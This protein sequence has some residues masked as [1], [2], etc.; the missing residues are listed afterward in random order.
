MAAVNLPHRTVSL[1]N[2]GVKVWY[3]LMRRS[4]RGGFSVAALPFDAAFFGGIDL[5]SRQALV[6][7]IAFHVVEEEV[8]RVGI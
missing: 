2:S 5:S 1:E 3:V 4:L 7:E 8:L 6:E